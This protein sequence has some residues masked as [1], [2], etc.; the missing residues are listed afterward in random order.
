M[1]K[2][3]GENEVCDFSLGNPV[4]PPP[5]YFAK[6]LVEIAQNPPQDLHSYMPNQGRLKTRAALAKVL[7]KWY[8]SSLEAK[9]ITLTVG[10]ASALTVLF[11]AM[12][13]PGDEVIVIAPYFLCYDDYIS[14]PGGVIVRVKAQAD[15]NLD[16]HAIESAITEK[17]RAIL[18]NSPNNPT[19]RIYSVK[20]LNTLASLLTRVYE[21][22]L[23]AAA[24]STKEKEDEGTAS[25]IILISDEPYRRLNYI[26]HRPVNHCS[27][28]SSSPPVSPLSIAPLPVSPLSTTGVPVIP[29]SAYHT[30]SDIFEKEAESQGL[31]GDGL[32]SMFKIYP[33]SIVCSSFSKDLSIPGERLGFLAV[34]P[35]LY[36]EDLSA[37]LAGTMRDCGFVNAPSFFQFAL[38][39]TIDHDI[40]SVTWYRERR[41]LLYAGLC[42][43]GLDCGAVPPEGAFYLFPK[44]PAGVSD[45]AFSD[46]LRAELVLSVPGSCFG[47]ASGV[48]FAYCVSLET[49]RTAIPRIKKVVEGIKAKAIAAK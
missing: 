23:A 13:N 11:H 27:D 47:D 40:S 24:I 48:R 26:D 2:K 10:A 5:D 31:G 22:R 34:P 45:T 44:V 41:D 30:S 1:K 39:T 21:S 29:S 8:D 35:A 14:A 7:S 12:L 28:T 37:S 49:I 17:T 38:E 36:S 15:F 20:T 4:L 18:I 3:H 43:A 32:P 25:P 42:A 19:G 46:L 33:Y 16:V 9:N 6:A